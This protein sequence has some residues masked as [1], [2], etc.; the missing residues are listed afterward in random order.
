MPT[1]G[2]G[3]YEL[4][5]SDSDGIARLMYIAK[6]AEAVYVLHVFQKKTQKTPQKDIDKAAKRLRDLMRNAMAKS[7]WHDLYPDDPGKVAQMETRANLMMAIGDR[8]REQGWNGAKPPSGSGSPPAGIGPDEREGVEVQRR[9][10]GEILGRWAWRSM[11][12]IPA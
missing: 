2:A 1:V 6:F 11:D 4:R 3:V 10:V 12:R 7:V 8:I 9:R 5:A